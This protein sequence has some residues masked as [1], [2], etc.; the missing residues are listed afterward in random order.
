MRQGIALILV[1]GVLVAW[2]AGSE[3]API[4]DAGKK[5][6]QLLQ[7]TWAIA[8]KEFMG[9]EATKD[10][11]AKLTGEIVIKDGKWTLR[12][13]DTGTGKK[14][15]VWEATLKLDPNAKPKALDLIYTSGELKGTTD[16][17]IYEITGDTLKVCYP[18]EGTER[19]TEFAGKA[20]GKALLMIYKRV[21]K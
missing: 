10:E 14:E 13:D 20:D 9:K 8:G 19:P 15:I 1:A 21:K 4:E 6:L 7:G 11:V 5:D 16:K 3:G 2:P 17:V 18:L 12:S